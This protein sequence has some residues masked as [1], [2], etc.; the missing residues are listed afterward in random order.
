MTLEMGIIKIEVSL[1]EATKAIEE[2]KRNPMKVFETLAMEIR[3]AAGRAIDQIL[4]AEMTF[5]LGHPDQRGNK[6][7]GYYEREFA[8]KG[9][10][11]VSIRMPIDRKRKFRSDVIVAHEQTDPRLK[12]DLAL[13]HL[14]GISTRTLG[15]IS[16]K[17][18]GVSVSADTV[19]KSV[20]MLSGNAQEWLGRKIDEKYWALFVDGTNF[21]IQRRGSTE[22]EPTLVVLGIDDSDR[23]SILALE[24]G[25][26]DSAQTWEELFKNLVSRGLNPREVRV[27]I[28]DGLTGLET[29]FKEA[30]PNS[31]TCRCWV[32]ALR[33][34]MAK[35]PQRLKKAFKPLV[36]R[37]MYAASQ[38][39]ARKA[40]AELK[41]AMGND[42]T[43]AVGILEKDLESLL[44]HYTFDKQYWRA[45]RTTNPIERINKEFKRRTKSMESVGDRTLEVLLVFIA[46]RLEYYWKRFPVTAKQF[47][48][49][50]A[51]HLNRTQLEPTVIQLFE[52]KN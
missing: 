14:S 18:L 49:L 48:A 24:P 46:L 17:V 32:H 30:F 1:P 45:L 21:R 10:G 29:K 23:M 35:V 5:F 2:I 4:N 28:M 40:F 33:N 8:L 51:Y 43:R 22:K 31:V 44:R 37:V 15:L 11:A 26:K 41:S 34:S 47:E 7:N 52:R 9:I 39:D 42:A 50:G 13:L 20:G 27:G 3:G 12:E 19:T 38:N 36:N 25:Y 16:E 6:R